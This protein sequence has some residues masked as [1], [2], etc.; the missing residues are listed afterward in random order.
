MTMTFV[1]FQNISYIYPNDQSQQHYLL[2]IFLTL[3]PHKIGRN[4]K[5]NWNIHDE[6]KLFIFISFPLL[7]I[8]SSCIQERMVEQSILKKASCAFSPKSTRYDPDFLLECVLFRIKSRA[9]YNHLRINNKLPLPCGET[10]RR[11]L[12]CMSC[13]FGLNGFALDAIKKNFV[14][15][16]VYMRYG[17]QVWD[18]MSIEERVPSIL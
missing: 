17:T 12:S 4:V 6:T 18:E 2:T 3:R 5:N 11:L 7:Q 13:T 16:P 10:I 15:K 9:A 8:Y 1:K 14:G